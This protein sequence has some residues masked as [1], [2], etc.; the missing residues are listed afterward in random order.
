MS[1]V[2]SKSE[3][4]S[5]VFDLSEISRGA[6]VWTYLDFP[7]KVKDKLLQQAL[8]VQE[9]PGIMREKCKWHHYFS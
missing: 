1:E 6:V 8:L 5:A 3:K 2:E 9:S 7:S 4:K